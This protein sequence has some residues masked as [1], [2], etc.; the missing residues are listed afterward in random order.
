MMMFDDTED[1]AAV[2]DT[3]PDAALAGAALPL[4]GAADS[5]T[6]DGAANSQGVSD[7]AL[8]IEELLEE[9]SVW[10]QQQQQQLSASVWAVQQCAVSTDHNS[11]QHHLMSEGR[12]LAMSGTGGSSA[13]ACH[14]LLAAVQLSPRAAGDVLLTT[15]ISTGSCTWQC[16][17]VLSRQAL[18]YA[19]TDSTMNINSDRQNIPRRAA[20]LQQNEVVV[21]AQLEGNGGD[22]CWQQL[23]QELD[24]QEADLIAHQQQQSVMQELLAEEQQQQDQQ[25]QQQQSVMKELLA[26]EQQQQD[27]QQQQQQSVMQELLAEEQQQ[28]DQQ[29]QQQQQQEQADDKESS[30]AAAAQ[31]I[32]QGSTLVWA[33]AATAAAVSPNSACNA[34]AAADVGAVHQLPGSLQGWQLQAVQDTEHAAQQQWAAA[35]KRRLMA[36][37]FRGWRQQLAAR[38]QRQEQQ[39]QQEQLASGFANRLRLQLL[40][41]ILRSWRYDFVPAAAA[42]RL[43]LESTLA[44]ADVFAAARQQRLKGHCLAGW[45]AAVIVGMSARSAAVQLLQT[46]WQQ[47]LLQDWKEVAAICKQVKATTLSAWREVAAA[48]QVK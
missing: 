22:P 19:E 31:G 25:Q 24:Q 2:A 17:P 43:M 27:Q 28:Q 30:D 12:P 7:A 21:E 8:V 18:Q 9:L 46:V 48:A 26:E 47:Q 45:T 6:A 36:V 13:V 42:D 39:Q 34:A 40:S 14:Q 11:Q 29:Q 35:C 38:Q 16:C 23:M 15:D 32:W 4:T 37:A 5:A 20:G 41:K 44:A 33:A 1:A 10:H 3:A